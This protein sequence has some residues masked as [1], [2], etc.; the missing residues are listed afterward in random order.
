[1]NK[2]HPYLLLFAGYSHDI[3]MKSHKIQKMILYYYDIPF[4]PISSYIV[5]MQSPCLEVHASS[6]SGSAATC[7]CPMWM[8]RPW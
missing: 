1:M 7:C 8:K 4:I 5:P 6:L 2:Y 3:S